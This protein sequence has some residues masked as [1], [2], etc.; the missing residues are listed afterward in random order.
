MCDTQL[1]Q[2]VWFLWRVTKGTEL[3]PKQ[4]KSKSMTADEKYYITVLLEL[5][6]P[7]PQIPVGRT[8]RMDVPERWTGT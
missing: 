6:S 7:G 3:K 8:S 1:L 4:W 5:I 2:K